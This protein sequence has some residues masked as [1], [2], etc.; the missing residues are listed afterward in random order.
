MD[1]S[2][3]KPKIAELAQTYGLSLVVLFGS[4]ATGKTH[5]ESDVDVAYLSGKKLSFDDEVQVNFRLTEIFR[6]DKVS[7]VNLKTASPLLLK[8][9][10]TKAIVLHEGM[11]HLFVEEFLRA[12]RLYEEAKPLFEL[13]RQ[14]LDQKIAEYR[15]G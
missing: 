13:R 12:L 1:F 4:Q 10:M 14:Y 11:P 8:Q 3:L 9:I 15:H 2:A 6:N 7:L 5:K